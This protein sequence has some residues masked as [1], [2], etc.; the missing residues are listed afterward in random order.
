MLKPNE[1]AFGLKKL[2]LPL[3]WTF[4]DF[5]LIENLWVILRILNL[6]YAHTIT[7]CL[8]NIS[9]PNTSPFEYKPLKIGLKMSM[10]PGLIFGIFYGICPLS[11][12]K[13]VRC[14]LHWVT[15]GDKESWIQRHIRIHS[16]LFLCKVITAVNSLFVVTFNTDRLLTVSNTYILSK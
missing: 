16:L 1:S 4:K 12:P 6:E 13:R 15:Y 10:S 5:I 3:I 14:T 7:K 2:F 11:Q 8:S 9:P